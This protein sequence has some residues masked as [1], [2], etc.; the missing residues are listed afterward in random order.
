MT[1]QEGDRPGSIYEIDQLLA[2][3]E[4]EKSSPSNEEI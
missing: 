1:L 2:A 4:K 3:K